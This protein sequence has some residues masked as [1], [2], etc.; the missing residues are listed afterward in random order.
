MSRIDALFQAS[1]GRT[2]ELDGRTIHRIDSV[3][4]GP[5]DRL[6]LT[7][8][9]IKS[10]WRQ[11]VRMNYAGKVIVDGRPF[12][13]HLIFWHDT[14][15]TSIEILLVEGD[16]RIEVYNAWDVGNGTVHYWHNGG[17]MVV[18]EVPNGRRYRCNDGYPD[19]D[20]DDLIFRLEILRGS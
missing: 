13:D 11:A 6:R 10:D 20:F 12:S 15:P 3:R 17:A 1:R 18:Q 5:G 2:A 8:E 14:A 9:S 7:F 16:D 4:V 19:E